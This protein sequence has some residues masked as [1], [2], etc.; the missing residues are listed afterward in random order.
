[1]LP[2]MRSYIPLVLAASLLVSPLLAAC[3]DGPGTTTMPTDGARLVAI[4]D[5]TQALRFND[6]TDLTVRYEQADGTPYRIVRDYLGNERNAENPF[7]GPFELPA[8]E[9]TTFMM[10]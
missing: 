6:R 7:P 8:G 9:A 3:S 4:S 10:R 2:F 5:L 1:M